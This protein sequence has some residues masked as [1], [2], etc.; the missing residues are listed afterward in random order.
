MGPKAEE[1]RALAYRLFEIAT[2]LEHAG[3]KQRPVQGVL[4]G[5]QR[6]QLARSH[7]GVRSAGSWRAASID[8]LTRCALRSSAADCASRVAKVQ[9]VGV[10]FAR[11]MDG[12]RLLGLYAEKWQSK[13]NTGAKL[14]RQ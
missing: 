14:L 9:F 10:V 6:D 2:Y 12:G 8:A 4:G 5:G 3:G 7:G 1:A 11:H 13:G